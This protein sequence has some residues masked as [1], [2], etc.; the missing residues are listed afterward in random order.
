MRKYISLVLVTV[1]AMVGILAYGTGRALADNGGRPI[2]V[3]MTG[4]EEAPGPGDPDGTGTAS[5]TFNP[6]LGQVCYTLTAENIEPATAAHIHI[7]PPGEPGPVVIPLIP[8]T[9][10]TSSGCASADRALIL[11]IIQ[12]PDAYYVNVHTAEH[13]AGAIRAQL[14]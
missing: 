7:A 5:F 4:A 11:N 8:P 14:G 6:G 10:G 12:N 2:S 13:P 3:V 9:S 1:L